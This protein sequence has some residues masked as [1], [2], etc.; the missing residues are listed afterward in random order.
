MLFISAPD[1]LLLLF[2]PVALESAS[3]VTIKCIRFF[4]FFQDQ[5]LFVIFFFVQLQVFY[6]AIIGG[7]YF[8]I[9]QTSFQY[10][11]GYYVS[12]LHRYLVNINQFMRYS[13]VHFGQ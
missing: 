10:I 4:L 11:P 8:I 7:T 12:V 3:S 6:V 5:F 1:T 2:T 13:F 9:V